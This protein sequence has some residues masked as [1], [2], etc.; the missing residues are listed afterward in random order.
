MKKV[1]KIFFSEDSN[2]VEMET[3]HKQ[4]RGDVLILLDDVIY[5]ITFIT[6]ERVFREYS[7]SKEN[8]NPYI[9]NSTMI[10]D[11]VDKQTIIRSIL[12]LYKRKMLANLRRINL[13]SEYED[14]FPELANINNWIQVY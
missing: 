10:V 7:Y 8:E 14:S 13:V 5:K 4:W 12:N 9:L 2:L 3:K 6:L 11:K 1:L